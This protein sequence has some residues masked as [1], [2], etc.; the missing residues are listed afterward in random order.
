MSGENELLQGEIPGGAENAMTFEDVLEKYGSL[1]YYNVGVSM[2]PLLH[3]RKDL[4]TVV[5]KGEERCKKG[6]VAL[7]RRRSDK[8]VLHRIIEVREKDY[9]ILGDNCF[10]KE[11]GITDGEILGV[12]TAYVRKGRSHSTGDLSYRLYSFYIMHTIAPR[13][14]RKKV[15]MKLKK[16]IKRMIGR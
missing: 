13:I 6:D 12:M 1:T 2:L 7:Y 9:V 4:F 16:V 15:M 11:Y 3:Q 14:F 5:R 10:E 8:Y